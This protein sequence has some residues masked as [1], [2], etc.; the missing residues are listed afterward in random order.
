MARRPSRLAGFDLVS[1][2]G[3]QGRDDDGGSVSP[4]AEDT[5]GDEI[6]GAFSPPGGLH[7]EQARAAVDEGADG[8]PLA[9]SELCVGVVEGLSEQALYAV[10]PDPGLLGGALVFDGGVPSCRASGW[11]QDAG[12]LLPGLAWRPF[13][14]RWVDRGSPARH[15]G[16]GVCPVLAG[17]FPS[18][19]EGK[20]L[21]GGAGGRRFDPGRVR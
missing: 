6:D 20:I 5:A 9:V 12:T 13:D 18:L 3:E 7:D 17:F 1:H 8:L 11:V 16:D 4:V 21:P 19:A 15:L 10:L 14:L 2:E